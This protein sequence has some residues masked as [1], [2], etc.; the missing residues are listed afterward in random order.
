M[1]VKQAFG[2]AAALLLA[3]TAAPAADTENLSSDTFGNRRCAELLE[4][5][6][7]KNH[8]DSIPAAVTTWTTGFLSG[9]NVARA[10]GLSRKSPVRMDRPA[11]SAQLSLY[12]KSNPTG[13]LLSAATS[14]YLDLVRMASD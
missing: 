1:K 8:P 6:S 11:V 4:T 10:A 3:A 13:T 12:C 7:K 9:M 14:V 5:G 2:V